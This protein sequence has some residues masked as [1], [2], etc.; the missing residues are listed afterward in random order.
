MSMRP[1][2]G[3]YRKIVS[4][5]HFWLTEK[6]KK[7]LS[8]PTYLLSSGLGPGTA[9]ITTILIAITFS[10]LYSMRS[11]RD[12]LPQRTRLDDR[13]RPLFFHLPG[14]HI[15]RATGFS[16]FAHFFGLPPL[17]DD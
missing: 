1:H 8:V 5:R 6:K 4:P 13:D 7:P 14:G 3:A 12:S 15:P 17:V 11:S 2:S 10:S 16:T 9:V